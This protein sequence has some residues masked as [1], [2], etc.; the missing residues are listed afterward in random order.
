[1][2]PQEKNPECKECG[3]LKSTVLSTGAACVEVDE[4]VHDFGDSPPPKESWEERLRDLYLISSPDEDGLITD[5]ILFEWARF[6]I[7]PRTKNKI[8]FYLTTRESIEDFIR[9]TLSSYKQE[10]VKV[11]EKAIPKKRKADR[12][13]TH[14]QDNCSCYTERDVQQFNECVELFRAAFS[15]LNKK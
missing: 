8:E 11:I 13:C 1:M 7:E 2:T 12:V 4:N 6:S 15:K 10:L 9:S 5:S 14:Y 3:L